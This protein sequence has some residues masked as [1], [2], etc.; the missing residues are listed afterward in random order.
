MPGSNTGSLEM[1]YSELEG[2]FWAQFESERSSEYMS[3][4]QSLRRHF[5]AADGIA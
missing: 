4:R 2:V 1:V 5:T 3:E